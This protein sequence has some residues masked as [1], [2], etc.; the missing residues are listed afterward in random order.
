MPWGSELPILSEWDEPCG[1][2]GAYFFQ[3]Q[4][5]ARWIHE[6]NPK[7]HVDVGSRLDGFIGSLSVFREVEVIDIR[8]QPLVVKNVRFHQLDLMAA[9]PGEWH[10]STDSL[11][12]LHTIEHFGL[13]RYGDPLDPLGH[14]KGLQQLKCMVAPGGVL[15][16]S[17]PIGPER[18]EFNAHRI[19]AAQTLL[20]WFAEG[21]EIVRFAV[22][23]DENRINENVDWRGAEVP[24]NFG[25]QAGVGIVAARKRQSSGKEDVGRQRQCQPN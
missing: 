24:T 23:D 13:G 4:L 22:I 10:G 6:L 3:D 21:W 15:Y 9:L 5:V 20:E 25:C 7:R 2:L 19:F 16:L 8:P 12:C 1:V 17:T 18:L 11:S 14:L